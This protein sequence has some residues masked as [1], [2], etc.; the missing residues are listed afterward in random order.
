[1]T[2]Y[3]EK[4]QITTMKYASVTHSTSLYIASYLQGANLYAMVALAE[5][6]PRLLFQVN[7]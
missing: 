2:R 6:L 3:V 4:Q 5:L 7:F 1:M